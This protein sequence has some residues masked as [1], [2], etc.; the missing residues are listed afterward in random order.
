MFDK[1]TTIDYVT[2][3]L[4]VIGIL[5]AFQQLIVGNLNPSQAAIF[6]TLM[7]VLSQVGSLLRQRYQIPEKPAKA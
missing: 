1:W 6:S 5:T 3:F 2:L 7:L 4:A